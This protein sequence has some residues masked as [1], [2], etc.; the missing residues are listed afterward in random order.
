MI[1][2]AEKD[3]NNQSLLHLFAQEDDDAAAQLARSDRMTIPPWVADVNQCSSSE[4]ML[5]Q[6]FHS[7]DQTHSLKQNT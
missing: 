6:A 1:L 3:S 2:I 7:K 5:V 4:D